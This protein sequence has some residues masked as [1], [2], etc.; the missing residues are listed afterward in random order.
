MPN[1]H[2]DHLVVERHVVDVITT[3]R[4]ENPSRASNGRSSIRMSDVGRR[5]DE[6]KRGFELVEEQIRRG[7]SMLAL[8]LIDRPNVMVGFWSGSN[9][10][11]H[12]LRRSSSMIAAAGRS[13]PACADVHDLES[14]SCRA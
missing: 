8:P 10:Q 3:T 12:P 5:A 1:R 14:V 7:R 4:Q 13:A 6:R 2:N 11:A 9:V